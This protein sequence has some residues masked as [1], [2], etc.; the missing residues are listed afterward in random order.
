[1]ARKN[2]PKALS[3]PS[4]PDS[5]LMVKPWLSKLAN[6]LIAASVFDDRC[7]VMWLME[8]TQFKYD[9]LA[10]PGYT[11]CVD[12]TPNEKMERFNAL[13]ALLATQLQKL[14]LPPDMVRDMAR[15]AEE[16]L[17]EG[18]VI[19]GRQVVWMILDHFKTGDTLSTAYGYDYILSLPW[20]GDKKI[21]EF[22][23]VW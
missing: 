2:R 10:N 6:A 5:H 21:D 14:K 22:I 4:F 12:A 18:K 8:C 9:E 13:D 3:V 16:I 19:A 7:E 15:N 20:Y 17:M 11:Q 1:M 23:H